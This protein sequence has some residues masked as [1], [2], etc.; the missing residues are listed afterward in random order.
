M[1]PHATA[2]VLALFAA[3]LSAQLGTVVG[4][5]LD[6]EA[7]TGDSELNGVVFAFGS[8]WITGASN[9]NRIYQVGPQGESGPFIGACPP[10][11]L[12]GA[13]DAVEL[14]GTGELVTASRDKLCVYTYDPQTGQLTCTQIIIPLPPM[15]DVGALGYDV[16]TQRFYTSWDDKPISVFTLNPLTLVATLPAQG[17]KWRGFAFDDAT[18]TLWATSEDGQPG[19]MTDLVEVH[20]LDPATGTIL[21]TFS[22]LAGL[23]GPNLAG[24]CTVRVDPANPCSTSLVVLQRSAPDVLVTYD[25]A[26]PT[27]AAPVATYCAAKVNSLGCV[28]SIR[29]GGCLGA[30]ATNTHAFTVSCSN[31]RNNKAGLM[32]YGL[33]GRALIPFQG[34]TLCVALPIRR[35]PAQFAGG[36]PP[37]AN[38][39]TGFYSVDMNAFAAG[40]LGGSPD[41]A[42]RN[43]GSVVATQFW[44]RDQGFPPP[45]N[46][47]LSDGL[48]YVVFP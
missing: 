11:T 44:G 48:E 1:R 31:V 35:T 22:G 42:L 29:A 25:L 43:V 2:L 38:D 39:C 19:T 7:P 24:G 47:M 36:T 14:P 41:P 33:G 40:Q 3:P 13:L 27:Q 30:S 5:P 28:P 45:M 10:A 17:K 16:A 26:L 46:T 34:G 20:Q 12:D 6:V 15:G 37:P 9:G 4:S 21:N 23:P 8:Y 32:L 18:G